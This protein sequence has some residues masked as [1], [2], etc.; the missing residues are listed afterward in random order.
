MVYFYGIYGLGREVGREIINYLGGFI[1]I[2]DRSFFWVGE[3]M[4]KIVENERFELSF[5]YI[6]NF[7]Y[8]KKREGRI[9]KKRKEGMI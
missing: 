7:L 3:E 8:G 5:D 9:L 6:G 1:S 2:G 4:E